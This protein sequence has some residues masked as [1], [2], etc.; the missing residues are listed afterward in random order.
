MGGD[1][2][3]GRGKPPKEHQ[4]KPGQSGNPK[5]RP[6]GAKNE[7]TILNEIINMK[8]AM[9]VDGRTRKVRF[10]KAMY[11]KVANDALKGNPKAV[12]LI[13]SRIPTLEDREDD[14]NRLDR[15]DEEILHAAIK[16]LSQGFKPS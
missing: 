14:P 5:G 3:V 15:D 4:F 16:R 7:A 8:V 12:A 1:Y 11:L 10:L 6:K 2:A 13:L 9:R